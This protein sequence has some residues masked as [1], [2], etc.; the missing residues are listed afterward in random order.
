MFPTETVKQ[1]HADS[2]SPE[3]SAQSSIQMKASSRTYDVGLTTKGF[4]R[5]KHCSK[6]MRMLG[7]PNSQRAFKMLSAWQS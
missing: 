2:L 3:P 7:S 1:C 6:A 4:T 5:K